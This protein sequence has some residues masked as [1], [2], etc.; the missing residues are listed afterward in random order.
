MNIL[1]PYP[2]G[3]ANPVVLRVSA[4]L[5]AAGA[6]D[7]TPIVSFSVNAQN[8]SL[9]FTYTRG[10]VGGAFDWQIEVSHCAVIG[11]VPAGASEWVTM[12]LYEPGNV[13]ASAATQSLVQTEYITFDDEGTG[14]PQD[15]VWAVELNGVIERVRVRARESVNGVVGTPG[16]LQITAVLV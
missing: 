14:D 8:M 6:W 15:F 11:L 9:D 4:A 3:Y 2:R 5:P 1:D 16:T 7:A 10:A 12:P 13:V